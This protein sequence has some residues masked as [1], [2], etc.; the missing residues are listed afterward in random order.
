MS[1]AGALCKYVLSVMDHLTR[2]ALLIPVPNKEPASIA[3]ILID[4]VIT[5][6]GIPEKTHSDRGSE[7]E[8][9]LIYALQVELGFH[10]T[11]TTP[12]RPQG[13]SVSERVHSTMHAMLAMHMSVGNKNWASLLPFVQMAYNTSYHSTVHETPYFL[14]FRRQPRLPVNIILGIPGESQ[15]TNQEEFS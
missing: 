15:A 13:N 8:N 11:K 7:F 9:Q 14:F 2:Y 3:K 1:N 5:T 6:F 12:L 10:K 4:R